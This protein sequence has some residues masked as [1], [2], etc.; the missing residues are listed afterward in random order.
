M[1]V[2]SSTQTKTRQFL[3]SIAQ[4]LEPKL[5]PRAMSDDELL[6]KAENAYSCL[7]EETDRLEKRVYRLESSDE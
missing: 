2:E 1:S 5:D 4:R 7:V 6:D 3:F